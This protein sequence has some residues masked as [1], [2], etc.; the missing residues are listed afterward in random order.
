[1]NDLIIFN[2][3]KQSIFNDIPVDYKSPNGN[4]VA[5]ISAIYGTI[6]NLPEKY[7]HDPCYRNKDKL[8]LSMLSAWQGNLKIT[9]KHFNHSSEMIEF[10]GMTVAMISAISI[11]GTI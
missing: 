10:S 4:T 7:N 8:T 9:P 1:M 2:K 6:S 11:K 5:M 3:I